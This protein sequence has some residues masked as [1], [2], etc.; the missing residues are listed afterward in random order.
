M[1][2][3]FTSHLYLLRNFQNIFA[4]NMVSEETADS[5][6]FQEPE[7]KTFFIRGSIFKAA[8]VKLKGIPYMTSVNFFGFFDPLF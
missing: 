7:K 1:L 2:A 8:D 4:P 6:E 3:T 5:V